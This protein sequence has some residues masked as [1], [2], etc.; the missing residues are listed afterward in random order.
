MRRKRQ[1]SFYLPCFRKF[2]MV[3]G[4]F[5]ALSNFEELA[6]LHLLSEIVE[7]ETLADMLLRVAPRY[8]IFITDVRLADFETVLRKSFLN[9]PFACFEAFLDDF[10][11]EYKI[12]VN[13]DFILVD[14]DDIS[15]LE[16][17]TKSLKQD[18]IIPQ[19]SSYLID[20]YT[21]FRLVRNQVTHHLGDDRELKNAYKRVE[22]NRDAIIE[23]FGHV[24]HTPEGI[25]FEDFKLCAQVLY[26]IAELFSISVE[27]HIDWGNL[28]YVEKKI[29][30]QSRVNRFRDNPKR[31][32]KYIDNSFM[33]NFGIKAP[34]KAVSR[35]MR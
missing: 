27:N 5:N 10:K 13:Q 19:I 1:T 25:T 14:D 28:D 3:F 11:A 31:L 18:R 23:R 26:E 33:S 32:R 16:K 24:P 22:K 12:F 20:L 8:N 4:E 2:K 29:V 9:H 7:N 6:S 35:I 17:F 21:Y 34:Q 15:K 30:S